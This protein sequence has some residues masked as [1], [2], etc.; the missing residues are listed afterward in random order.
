MKLFT[1]ATLV[2]LAAAAPSIAPNPKVNVKLEMQE[3]SKVKATVS[4]PTGESIKILKTG[5]ILD[6]APV[7]KASVSNE[8]K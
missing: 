1:V 3:N 5:S 4:N 6:S 8:G 7:Q 2:A